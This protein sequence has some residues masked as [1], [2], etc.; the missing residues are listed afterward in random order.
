MAQELTTRFNRMLGPKD[1][2][3]YKWAVSL[4]CDP[5]ADPPKTIVYE[6]GSGHGQSLTLWRFT[7]STDG[8]SYNIHGLRYAVD[9]SS[10][11]LDG[12]PSPLVATGQ[13]DATTVDQ[14]LFY[15]SA[16]LNANLSRQR[17]GSGLG[18]SGSFSS[19]DFYQSISLTDA[20]GHRVAREYCGYASSSDEAKYLPLNL[21]AAELRQLVADLTFSERAPSDADRELFAAHISSASQRF[22]ARQY[23]WVKERYAHMSRIYGSKVLIPLLLKFLPKQK[24]ENRSTEATRA[25]AVDALSK[26]TGWNARKEKGG[27]IERAAQ[28]YLTECGRA[29]H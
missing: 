18:F 2:A 16:A 26:I 22:N 1:S 29:L 7:Q 21:A 19:R 28:A 24:N 15:A 3:N 10:G 25:H 17:L 9:R 6:T 27:S 8:L 5:L 14:R 12:P 13:V 23:W 20:A 4:D 11:S